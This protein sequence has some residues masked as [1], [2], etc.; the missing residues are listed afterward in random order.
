LYIK[1][2]GVPEKLYI[3]KFSTYKVNYPKATYEKDMKTHFSRAM[4]EV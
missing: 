1:Q 2:H 3:D 4:Q